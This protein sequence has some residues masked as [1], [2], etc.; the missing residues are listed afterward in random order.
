MKK[1]KSVGVITSDLF[2]RHLNR[3]FEIKVIKSLPS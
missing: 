3:G 1:K 2:K